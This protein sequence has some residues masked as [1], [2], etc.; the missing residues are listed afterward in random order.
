[1]TGDLAGASTAARGEARSTTETRRLA[2]SQI[3]IAGGGFAAV[4]TAAAAARRRLEAGAGADEVP[5][6]LVAPRD[7][8][9]IRPRLYEARPEEMRV[10]LRRI[11]DPIGVEHVRAAVE[12][13]DVAA[14][15][16]VA[17]SAAGGHRRIGFDR[18]VV[19]AGSRLVRRAGFP[20][21]GRFHDV[22]TLPAAVALDH[23]LHLLPSLTVDEG[24]WTA[25]IAGAG[26][27]GIEL[28]TELVGRLR[29]IAAPHGA[30]S[31]VRV[32]LVEREDV[33]GP[34]LGP[35]P[36]PEIE[37]AL[38]ALGVERRLGTTVTRYDGARAELSDGT[39]LAALTAVWTAGMAA[40]PITERVP[41]P[42]D[43]LGRL[44]IDAQLRVTGLQTVFAAGDTASAAVD[45]SGRRALQ[46]CQYAHQ[47][48]K[49]A[50]HNAASDLLGLP[51][52]DFAPDPYVTCVDLGEAGAVYTQGHDRAVR[53]TGEAGKAIKRTI[54]CELIYPPLDDAAT[55]LARAD[56]LAES[57]PPRPRRVEEVAGD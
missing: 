20:G 6:V 42:R 32:V 57:R 8:M 24:R 19:A 40:A 11:L 2:L 44:E 27:V 4:W 49:V 21:A 54:N 43:A 45:A 14:G 41:A 26:F 34:E 17:V 29:A 12:D 51:L 3:V 15:R 52:V 1:V 39:D 33:V 18:L 9:V 10:D 30:G 7:D 25:L 47:L 28:A 53:A 22:D 31:D 13:V 48:G 36:R 16:V 5:T 38:D 50:G 23:H 35:G 56:H 55:I 37:R 46:A